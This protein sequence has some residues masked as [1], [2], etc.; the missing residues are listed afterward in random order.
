MTGNVWWHKPLWIIKLR[1]TGKKNE[2]HDEYHFSTEDVS[3]YNTILLMLFITFIVFLKMIAKFQFLE[4][5]F[6]KCDCL[7]SI[8]PIVMIILGILVYH[9]I[10]VLCVCRFIVML[11]LFIKCFCSCD[12]FFSVI[13]FLLVVWLIFLQ[14]I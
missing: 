1:I 13:Y 5:F 8:M 7:F 14:T 12:V 2:N 10:F 3:P 9:N 11:M 4:F 6:V